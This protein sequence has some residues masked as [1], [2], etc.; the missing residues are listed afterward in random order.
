M[1]VLTHHTGRGA[2]AQ[3]TLGEETWPI[4]VVPRVPADL[5]AQA[6]PHHACPHM[7]GLST[8]VDLWRAVLADV[9]GRLAQTAA[10]L[11][12]LVAL[13]PQRPGGHPARGRP[14]A[15][16]AS[17]PCPARGCPHAPAA[18]RHEGR[19]ERSGRCRQSAARH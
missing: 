16:P 8:P 13:A 5:A 3:L 4:A 7:R 11:S 12:A 2:E 1:R 17:G 19:R 10:G 6:R 15:L 14:A 18:R 9:L